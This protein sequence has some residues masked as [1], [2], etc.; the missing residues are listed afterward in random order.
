MSWDDLK[1]L[2][3][4]HQHRSLLAAGR[5]LG[6]STSTTAR[7]LDRLEAAV[8]RRIVKRTTGGTS[9]EPAAMALVTLAEQVALGVA[10]AGRRDDGYAG[11]VRVSTGDG[12]A[13]ALAQQLAEVR[14]VH[15]EI[16]IELMAEARAVDIARGE[17][18]VCV[19]TTRTTSAVV[20]EKP[21]GKLSFGLYASRRYVEARLRST[22]LRK[23]DLASLDVVAHSKE[24]ASR[25]QN[26]WLNALGAQRF[27]F[28]SNSDAVILEAAK[29]SQGICVLADLVGRAEPEL[30]RLT[31]DVPSPLLP[32]WLA[33]HREARAQPRIR[34]VIEALARYTKAALRP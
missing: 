15:P 31:P 23:G 25:L 8:G 18:D 33:F 34:V 11:T 20:V 28:R 13:K 9:I 27:V 16:V 14:R 5:A 10:S 6:M 1:V 4:V 7:R 3:A 17:A 12:L 30:V 32:V 22:T 19:R 24:H 29:A 21:L 2:L 26:A